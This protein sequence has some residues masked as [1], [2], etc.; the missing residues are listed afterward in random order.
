MTDLH[1]PRLDKNL[2]HIMVDIE[3]TSVSPNAGIWQIGACVF[4][5]DHVGYFFHTLNVYAIDN[6]KYHW[7]RNTIEWQIQHNSTEWNVANEIP[8]DTTM[9]EFLERFSKW[10]LEQKKNFNKSKLAIWSKGSYFDIPILENAFK[11]ENISLPWRY[12]EIYDARTIFNLTGH[13]M[14]RFDG[15]HNALNDARHQAAELEK[16]FRELF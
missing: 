7:D 11:T 4:N 3:T 9:W 10:I 5:E 2:L 8:N 6:D 14:P 1:L 13:V 12:N 15:A 16:V